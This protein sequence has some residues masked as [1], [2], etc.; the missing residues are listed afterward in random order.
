MQFQ[1]KWHHKL[2]GKISFIIDYR[3]MT[4]GCVQ[5][6]LYLQK[7]KVSMCM[8]GQL[9]LQQISLDYKKNVFKGI[10]HKKNSRQMLGIMSW[11]LCFWACNKR[12]YHSAPQK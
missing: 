3:S 8:Q 12:D 2:Q 4:G 11:T 7:A 1:I 10:D 9:S 6:Y 5:F